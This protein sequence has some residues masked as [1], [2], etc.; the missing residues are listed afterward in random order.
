MKTVLLLSK[1]FSDLVKDTREDKTT[2]GAGKVQNI[3]LDLFF[4]KLVLSFGF[5]FAVDRMV[6][7]VD[8]F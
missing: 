8:K 1:N 6:K 5:V 7:K 2:H 3:T 4:K